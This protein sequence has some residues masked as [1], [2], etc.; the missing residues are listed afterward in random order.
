M[1]WRIAVH[2]YYERSRLSGRFVGAKL[3]VG[4]KLND[5]ELLERL[6]KRGHNWEWKCRCYCGTEFKALQSNLVRSN[7]RSC[8]CLKR[9]VL[10]WNQ[11][12]HGLSEHPIYRLWHNMMRRCYD[13][14]NTRYSNYGG[15]G[16]IVCNR[17]H[18]P[19][20]F[21][22]D[23][24]DKPAGC[25]L[26]RKDNNSGYSPENCVWATAKQQGRNTRKNVYVEIDGERICIAEL[27]EKTG[28]KAGTLYYRKKAGWLDNELTKQSTPRKGNNAL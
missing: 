17:W 1:V 7:T 15:R 18:S 2:T 14:K 9:N 20:K 16:I 12:E 25:S 10:L 24:G 4:D 6:S 23:M 5:V 3:S 8:G 13:N 27:A 28:I 11:Y 19:D 21:Y 26:E 22:E